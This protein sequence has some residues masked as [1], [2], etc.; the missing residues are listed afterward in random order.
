MK[1]KPKAG[2]ALKVKLHDVHGLQVKKTYAQLNNEHYV[3]LLQATLKQHF[4]A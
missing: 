1:T 3:A 4:A 2:M